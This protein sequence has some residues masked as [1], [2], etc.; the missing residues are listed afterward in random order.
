MNSLTDL[1][2]RRRISFLQYGLFDVFQYLFLFCS[3]FI[4]SHGYPPIKC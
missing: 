4:L 3:N 1:P 2:D